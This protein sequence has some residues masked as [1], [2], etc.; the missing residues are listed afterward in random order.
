V[1][2]HCADLYPSF[3]NWNTWGFGIAPKNSVKQV[4]LQAKRY[5]VKV[6]GQ[7]NQPPEVYG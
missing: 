2:V 6:I 4:K 3:A 7:P 1:V 5:D